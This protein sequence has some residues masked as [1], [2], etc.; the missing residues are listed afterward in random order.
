M[1]AVGLDA[2]QDLKTILTNGWIATNTDSLTPRIQDNLETYW[3]QLDFGGTDQLYI[4]ADLETVN[5]GL[6]ASAFFH[7]IGCTIE[8]MTARVTTPAAG[9]SH[10]NKMLKET[11]RIIKAN[12]RY[13]G[14]QYVVVTSGKYRFANDKQIFIG[15]VEV[16]LWKVTTS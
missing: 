10:F 2:V 11:M 8:V 14:Y 9:R 1:S 16:E 3:S 6:H 7:K 15:A 5:T 12:A 13:A 4:K